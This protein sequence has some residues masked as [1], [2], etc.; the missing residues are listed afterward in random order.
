AIHNDGTGALTL[1]GDLSFDAAAPTNDSL[2][3]G[4]DFG[5]TNSF[6]GVISGAGDLMSTGSSTWELSGVNI[7]TGAITVD[8]GVLRAGGASA[9]G[10]VTGITVNG[11]TLDLNGSDLAAPTLAGTGG[12]VALGLGNLT[13]DLGIG[14]SSTY[15]GSITGDGS[16]T[17]L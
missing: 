14:S 4:G 8:G 6:S 16:L 3:F 7:R 2:T 17:K 1:S 11:G 15:G 9:F 12:A 5:G 10:A 13:V